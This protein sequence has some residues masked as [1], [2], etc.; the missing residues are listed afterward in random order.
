VF[1]LIQGRG[2]PYL[3]PTPPAILR[4][5]LS[6]P[7]NVHEK[8]YLV[9]IYGALLTE[10]CLDAKYSQTTRTQLRWNLRLAIDDARLLLEPSDLNIQA[11]MILAFH[12]QEVTTPSLSWM[13]FST[14]CRMLQA[15]G[16]DLRNL[17]PEVRERRIMLFWTFNAIDKNLAVIFGRPPALH[18]STGANVPTLPVHKLM[19]YRP[20]Q[21]GKDGTPNSFQ[22]TYGAHFLYFLHRSSEVLTE[23]WSCLFEDS[24]KFDSAREK[25]D[26]WHQK[27][28]SVRQP[29]QCRRLTLTKLDSR[30]L[31]GRGATF[32]RRRRANIYAAWYSIPT[33]PV[34][35]LYSA[36]NPVTTCATRSLHL[37]G[38]AGPVLTR[39][40]GLRLVRSIQ[41]RDMGSS[42]LP[43]HAVLH[44]VWSDHIDWQQFFV[45]TIIKSH[46]EHVVL[47]PADGVSTPSSGKAAHDC[48]NICAVCPT[49][50]RKAKH[51][52]SRKGPC[53]PDR[54]NTFIEQ[55]C[56]D[57]GYDAGRFADTEPTASTQYT[58][59]TF[60][61]I[62]RPIQ[63]SSHAR[64]FDG[65]GLLAA[66]QRCRLPVRCSVRRYGRDTCWWKNQQ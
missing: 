1:Y 60:S 63:R 57:G 45:T 4:D 20:H 28:I 17:E 51:H 27:M 9:L 44:T 25:L 40:F 30:S 54:I 21:V 46:G 6:S 33:I 64:P 36:V 14:I 58:S 15:L 37:V 48:S 16:I 12:V 65:H 31:L 23:I 26:E 39:R 56:H 42:V 8:A 22:S 41:R 19:A 49:D 34:L 13:V 2:R 7:D 43:V 53:R 10:A 29:S 3:T 38:T 32:P 62:A 55:W 18:N 52:Y 61:A 5:A 47:P 50:L 35:L 66:Q 11:L 24:S 59:T